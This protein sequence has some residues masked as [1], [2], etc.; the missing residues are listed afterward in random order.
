MQT[1][2]PDMKSELFICVDLTGLEPATSRV[3]GG[4]SSQMSYRP[5]YQIW[6]GDV[7]KLRQL[8]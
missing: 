8:R 6:C 3:Q 4:R 1:K 5:L 2:S 7:P